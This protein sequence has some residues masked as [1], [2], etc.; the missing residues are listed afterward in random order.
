LKQIIE[1]LQGADERSLILLDEL[2]AGTDPIEGAALGRALLDKF[3]GAGWNTVIT[4][5]IGSLKEYAYLHEGVENAAMEFD[6]RS[7]KPTYRLLMGVPGSSNALAIARRIGL[8]I[9]VLEAAER[10][11]ASV[12]EPTREVIR[13]MQRSRRRIERERRRTEEA[14]RQVEGEVRAY[15]ER[16]REVDAVEEA[17]EAE[18][19]LVVDQAVRG[20]REKLAPL[21]E[22]LKNVPRSHQHVVERLAAEVDGLLVETPL[23]TR[24]EAFA[25][26]LKKEDEVYIPKFRSRAKVR[27]VDK[28]GRVLTV[29]L[30]GI[31]TEISFDDISWLDA[32]GGAPPEGGRA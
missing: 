2:G 27:K 1:V 3:L 31:L 5:H 23:G 11:M 4:T 19:Q 25:R 17:L 10:E 9:G 28:G 32:P 14:R 22:Q 8:D 12:N 20:A 26:G 21:I 24:R 16:R 13:R 30:N 15:E 7:L 6:D 29:L 18:A